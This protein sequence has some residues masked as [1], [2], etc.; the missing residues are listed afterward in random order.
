MRKRLGGGQAKSLA[1][2]FP[3]HRNSPSLETFRQGHTEEFA[4]LQEQIHVLQEQLCM[5][6]VGSVTRIGVHD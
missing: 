5:L 3:Y 6:I 1:V 4:L 2:D